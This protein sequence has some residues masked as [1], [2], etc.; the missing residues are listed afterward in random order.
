MAYVFA[1]TKDTEMRQQLLEKLDEKFLK[2]GTGTSFGRYLI[3]RALSWP[4][5]KA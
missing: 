5:V 3:P 4:V 2:P 1:L